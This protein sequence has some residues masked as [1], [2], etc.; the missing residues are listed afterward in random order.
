MIIGFSL[1]IISVVLFAYYQKRK[2]KAKI[3]LM[4]RELNHRAK[5]NFQQLSGLLLLYHNQLKD[6]VAKKAIKETANR[7]QAMGVVHRKLYLSEDTTLVEID[8]FIRELSEELMLSYGYTRDTLSLNFALESISMA[9]DKAV[10]LSLIINELLTNA[11]KYAF[12]S[13]P[14]PVLDVTLS[15]QDKKIVLMVQDNGA[16]IAEHNI[17]GDSFGLRLIRMLCRQINAELLISNNR[18]TCVKISMPQ[19]P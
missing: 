9:A 7:V 18:G 3:E 13:N 2:S 10:P 1:I 14:N 15:R 5:N 17:S 8:V 4:M 16:G 12:V 11:F 6:P 19:A